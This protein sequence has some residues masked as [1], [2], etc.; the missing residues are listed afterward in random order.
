MRRGVVI[1]VA[2]GSLLLVAPVAQ[3]DH[4]RCTTGPTPATRAVEGEMPA[5]LVGRLGVLRR[6]PRAGDPQLTSREHLGFGVFESVL[7]NQ[8]RFLRDGPAGRRFFLVPGYQRRVGR[9]RCDPELP[10]RERR[11]QRRIEARARRRPP[12]A[13]LVLVSVD[14]A[15][16]T[17]GTGVD[18]GRLGNSIG[19]D[20]TRRCSVLYGVVPDGVERVRLSLNRGRTLTLTVVNNL[21]VAQ[22]SIPGVRLDIGTTLWLGP[23]GRVLRRFR[24]PSSFGGAF[25]P[26]PTLCPRR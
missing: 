16:R 7:T 13:A 26:R 1:G 3:A 19:V 17:S 18:A 25:S 6:P 5:E 20:A 12:R 10:A 23:E 2:V 24:R 14:R 22:V 15:G 4:R 21:W 8:V 9:L 11:R